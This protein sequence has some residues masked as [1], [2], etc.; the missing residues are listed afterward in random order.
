MNIDETFVQPDVDPTLVI[1]CNQLCRT[2]N[3]REWDYCINI[4][5]NNPDKKQSCVY[6]RLGDTETQW[7]IRGPNGLVSRIIKNGVVV[8]QHPI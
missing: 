6:W 2:M 4:L 1:E 5:Q 3:S 7:V 8:S